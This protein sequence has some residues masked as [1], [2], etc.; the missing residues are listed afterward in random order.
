VGF[1]TVHL[2]VGLAKRTHAALDGFDEPKG[3]S[4]L[5]FAGVFAGGTVNA[6]FGHFPVFIGNCLLH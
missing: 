6:K 5:G 2:F 4:L 3:E 1:A